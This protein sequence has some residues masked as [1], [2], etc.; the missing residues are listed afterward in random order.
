MTE[1]RMAVAITD[2]LIGAGT[3]IETF[4]TRSIEK[5]SNARSTGIPKA[6]RIYLVKPLSLAGHDVILPS[7]PFLK[8]PSQRTLA[9]TFEAIRRVGGDQ[10][11][12]LHLREANI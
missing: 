11:A 12:L 1:H 7:E 9:R 3:A 2:S 8:Q 5:Q 6:D 4:E 10:T